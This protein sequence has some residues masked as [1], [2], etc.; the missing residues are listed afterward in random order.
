MKGQPEYRR[1]LNRSYMVWPL[2]EGM[3]AD[4]FPV[5]MV[6]SNEIPG[7][8]RG[9]LI[10]MDGEM[11]A[12]YDIT[13]L[14]SVEQLYED[15]KMTEKDVRLIA[16]GVI[17]MLETI[18][19]YFISSE[20]LILDAEMIYT[21]AARSEIYI[22]CL[23]G[24][25]EPVKQ[26]FLILME[27]MLPKLDHKDSG[28]VGLGYGLYRVSIGEAFAIEELKKCLYHEAEEPIRDADR[29]IVTDGSL[30]RDAM[31][32]DDP[33]TIPENSSGQPSGDFRNMQ[34]PFIK[35]GESERKVYRNTDVCPAAMDK[36]R[37]EYS[38]HDGKGI[39]TSLRVF[40]W[41]LAGTA[42]MTAV[43]VAKQLGY[44]PSIPMEY[45]LAAILAIMCI[46]VLVCY[47]SEKSRQKAQKQMR[48]T[49]LEE[50]E[51]RQDPS[52]KK[53]TQWSE[54][55]QWSEPARRSEP[56]QWSEHARRREP[57][58]WSEPEQRNES[59]RWNESV[60]QREP[61][62][63]MVERR[64]GER[65]DQ[66]KNREKAIEKSSLWQNPWENLSPEQKREE[67]TEVFSD[68]G[69]GETVVLHQTKG[70]QT[71]SLMSRKAGEYPPIFLDKELIVLGKLDQAVDAVIACPTVS[72]IHAKIRKKEEGYFLTDLNSM[73]GTAVNG[74]M[75]SGDEEY[76]LHDQDQVDFA[77]A[78]Y[79]FL[80]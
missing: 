54:P 76:L 69:D 58:Q 55:V 4:T 40:L 75:L 48:W 29:G 26:Q 35:A 33:I 32:K 38:R 19:E 46:C 20:S 9:K 31:I 11:L 78:G 28:A 57:G 23:P 53:P 36:S 67:K 49:F 79:I 17:R 51:S 41:I 10:G 5:R 65:A 2:T 12:Y 14:Q 6:M 73:N 52:E 24:Y 27:Y 37:Q 18:R 16:G 21:N 71:A 59:A 64:T 68:A 70:R 66:V 47:V 45:L 44:L 43:V 15:K 13:S 50:G 34:S 60:Q 74:R 61:V 80:E 3:N 77:E 42:C 1:E 72:R 39:P 63:M 7:L 25:Q 22:C 56:G 30:K 62:F 8:L